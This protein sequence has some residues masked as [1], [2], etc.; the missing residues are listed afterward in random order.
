MS[1]SGLSKV[2]QLLAAWGKGDAAALASL[3]PLVHAELH[4]IASRHMRGERPGHV[5]QPTAL[6]NEAWLRLVNASERDWHNRAHFYGIAAHLMRQILIDH[7]RAVQR[8]KRGGGAIAIPLDDS[9]AL[10]DDHL[11]DLLILDDALKRLAERDIRKS[12]VF[13]LRYFG[14]LSVEETADV[15]SVAPNTII[16]DWAFA[17]AWL[18]RELT[19]GSA[20]GA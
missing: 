12:R 1:T 19:T 17:R 4:R 15:L 10:S 11:P 7:A 3:A 13:E 20:D 6:I 9:L 16:R 2:S 18:S 14:G 8:D 5:L